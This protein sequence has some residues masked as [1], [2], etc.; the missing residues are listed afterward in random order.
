MYTYNLVYSFGI[1]PP[2]P[3]RCR[4]HASAAEWFQERVPLPRHIASI[5]VEFEE[6]ACRMT[7]LLLLRCSHAAATHRVFWCDGLSLDAWLRD[8][9]RSALSYLITGIFRLILIFRPR[10]LLLLFYE[11]ARNY[12]IS[13]F[14]RR[15]ARR[16][17]RR[18]PMSTPLLPH[19]ANDTAVMPLSRHVFAPPD[20]SFAVAFGLRRFLIAGFIFEGLFTPIKLAAFHRLIWR[21]WRE[22]LPPF[23]EFIEA[24]DFRFSGWHRQQLACP[25]A[26]S[27]GRC[28]L[29]LPQVSM[30]KVIA[31]FSPL[32][33]IYA[34]RSP[35][36][37]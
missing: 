26:S 1:I 34:G 30:K 17:R 2:L 13:Q 22:F 7:W 10:P 8:S 9:R 15:V 4:A 28:L 24:D 31:R 11:P 35:R 20:L 29:W 32:L 25:L 33:H 36:R 21:R 37:C 12:R 18:S 27:V 16:R 23:R 19:F 3:R 5:S 14:Y 6:S